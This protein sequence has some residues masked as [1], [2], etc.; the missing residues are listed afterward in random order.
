M[1][2]N[3]KMKRT[4]KTRRK[5]YR[6]RARAPYNSKGLTTLR[7]TWERSGVYKIFENGKI[8]YI[9]YSAKNLY[10]TM[11]RHFQEWN[12]RDQPVITYAGSKKK[13]KVQVTLCSPGRAQALE[14]A[15]IVR[16]KPRDNPN[17][18]TNYTITFKDKELLND[19]EQEITI[20][21][22][23]LPF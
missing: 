5:F 23:D 9:G 16:L 8:V 10:K 13:Y 11:Y 1:Y 18:Y 3:C 17:K 2:K 15:L 12:H 4:R 6:L 14:R 7:V 22:E 21:E 20:K 19:W